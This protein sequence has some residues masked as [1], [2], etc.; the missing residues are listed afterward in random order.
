MNRL[1]LKSD[2][3]GAARGFLL[4]F[5]LAAVL[6][7]SVRY[8]AYEMNTEQFFSA[9]FAKDGYG[10]ET[11]IIYRVRAPRVIS[12]VVA[13][14]GLSLSGLILQSVTSNPLAAPSIIGINSGAGLGV[15]IFLSSIPLSMSIGASALM[16][17]FAFFGA[18]VT[19]I[20]VIMLSE[21]AGGG[22]SSIVLAGV[23][24]NAV[25]NAAIGAISLLDTDVLASYN[26]FSIGGFSSTEYTVLA[27]P[28]VIVALCAAIAAAFSREINLLSLGAGGAHI[29]GVNVRRVRVICVVIASAAAAS[30]VSIAGLVGFV[31][32]VVP[33]ISRKLTGHGF[34][35]N[36]VGSCLLGALVTTLADLLGRMLF[37]PTEIPVGIMM[38]LVGAPFFILLLIGGR[39]EYL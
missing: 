12:A 10:T 30:A 31:G 20:I 36:L 15:M 9:L 39:R 34:S 26:S 37:S 24:V 11:L 28:A 32:L 23:A 5:A 8:G 2:K 33:H 1:K 4:L 38:A 29:L 22:K 25:F 6:V 16:Q 18:F 35:Q 21:G 3:R 27:V 19:T 17:L 13:G 14:V 7:L